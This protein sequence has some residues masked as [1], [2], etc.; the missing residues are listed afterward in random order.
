VK[1]R[2]RTALLALTTFVSLHAPLRAA[3][4]AQPGQTQHLTSLDET[5][6]GLDERPV[7]GGK[8]GVPGMLSAK[9]GCGAMVAVFLAIKSA[10]F[11]E[12]P[13]PK[14]GLEA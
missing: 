5:P 9:H 6:K 12:T 4:P 13:L 3:S 11:P 8:V 14:P 1:T 10:L 7:R 2:L